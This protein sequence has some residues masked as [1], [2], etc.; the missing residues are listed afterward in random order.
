MIEK[1]LAELQEDKHTNLATTSDKFK[2][3]LWNFFLKHNFSSKRAIEFGT[4]KGQTT[5]VLSHLFDHV[6]TINID[7]AHLIAAMDLNADRTN[8]TYIPFDL[9]KHDVSVK[10][11]DAVIDVFFIDAGHDADQV[12]S[13]VA[14]CMNMNLGDEVYFIFDDY[15]MMS[16]VKAVIDM[17]V[18]AELFTIV[19]YIG[20]ETGHSFGGVPARVLRGPEGVICKLNKDKIQYADE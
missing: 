11:T 9:Y 6:Y 14:R 7:Y 15:G 3:D 19:E 20:H 1:I 2:Y 18:N 16:G 4:H 10:P 17:Y 13:D 5:R 12:E 8:I